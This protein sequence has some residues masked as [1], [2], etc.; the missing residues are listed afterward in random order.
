ME[1]GWKFVVLLEEILCGGECGEGLDV[2]GGVP[3]LGWV[4]FGYVFG[5]DDSVVWVVC[6]V[7]EGVGVG[8]EK[9]CDEG[10]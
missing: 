2:D 1:E 4:W 7:G 9:F 3:C 6:D 8:G 5:D 10:F